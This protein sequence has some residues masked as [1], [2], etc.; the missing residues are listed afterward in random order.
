MR[1]PLSPPPNLDSP[2]VRRHLDR[3]VRNVLG[4][5]D[6]VSVPE[7]PTRLARILLR[8]EEYETSA[9][10]LWGCWEYGMSDNFRRGKL[11]EPEVDV[12]ISEIGRS[13]P[14]VDRLPLWP[15]G[16][17]FVVCPTH[18]VDMVSRRWTAAQG[19]RSVRIAATG[20][21]GPG[22]VR[23]ARVVSG[24]RAAGR[25]AR[26]GVSTAPS[27]AAT[28]ERCVE[29]ESSRGVTGSYFFTVYS[30]DAPSYY[31]CV[32]SPDDPLVFRGRRSSVG[33]V[34]R[35]LVDEG[36]DV[37]LHGSYRS[38][39]DDGVLDRQRQSLER[40]A[41]AITTTRQHWLHWRVDRTPGL[42][43]AAGITADSTLGFNRNVG[44]RAGTSFPFSLWDAH[45]SRPL[46][47]LEIP[48]IA[49]ESGLVSSNALELNGE[50][51]QIV[52]GT[53]ME[54][55]ASVGGVLTI[56]V[57]PHS[58]LVPDVAA[59]YE[60]V[61]D[62][63]LAAGAWVTSIRE[64]ERWWRGREAQLTPLVGPGETATQREP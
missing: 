9:R 53:L 47:V 11:W 50:Q 34:M 56:L 1:A 12:W 24:I 28:L 23:S 27:A 59:L 18:D 19:L 6:G 62:E 36:F 7:M 42:Q 10:D 52:L 25:L 8:S 29:V 49:Q 55:V 39:I 13:L 15:S 57:H 16:A 44:F 37:G 5:A 40:V 48:L 60:W 2:E 58:L 20:T 64:V 4:V 26:F 41:G 61:L 32:Y 35:L 31:D 46:D 54:R 22:S 30:P 51:S 17:P 3:F 14:D 21:G 38:A 43:E 33:D 45:A 63:A